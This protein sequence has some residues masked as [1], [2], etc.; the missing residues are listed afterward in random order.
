MPGG[1]SCRVHRQKS[2]PWEQASRADLAGA[3]GKGHIQLAQGGP[4]MSTLPGIGLQAG[5]TWRVRG[6]GL[7]A[8]ALGFL[9][10][11]H[12]YLGFQRERRS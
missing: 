4:W 11:T 7:E 12:P 5:K 9:G 2:R 6:K 1:A 8:M 10:G 3:S